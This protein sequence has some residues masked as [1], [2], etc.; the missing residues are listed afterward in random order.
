M[1]DKRLPVA[2]PYIFPPEWFPLTLRAF[3]MDTGEQVWEQRLELAD[4]KPGH[5]LAGL[6]IPP[7]RR[8]YGT[9]MEIEVETGTGEKFR[10]EQPE[11]EG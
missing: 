6:R 2:G 7:L 3:R 11:D 4:L 1:S 9:R 10:R 5:G 8:Q